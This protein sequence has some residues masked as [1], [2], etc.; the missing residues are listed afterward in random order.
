MANEL[1]ELYGSTL[2]EWRNALML[3][4]FALEEINTKLNI[5]SAEF[6]TIQNRS[7]IEHMKSRIK[8]F[9]SIAA[10]LTRKGQ[11]VTIENA[12][13]YLRDIAGVR[14]IC[15]FTDDIYVIAKMIQQQDD[16]N[17]I[18]VKDYIKHPKPNGY[19][20]LHILIEIPVFLSNTTVYMPVEIQIRT[21]AMDFWASLEHKIYYKYSDT[22][23]GEDL[24]RELRDIANTMAKLDTRMLMIKDEIEK[25]DET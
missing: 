2:K 3:Y 21:S 24:T 19:R 22:K 25:M 12:Q 14:I 11:D 17:I 10:K 1:V 7:P 15:S 13:K 20:S 9:E 4:E 18:K 5:L 16:I 8:S 6:R 23:K